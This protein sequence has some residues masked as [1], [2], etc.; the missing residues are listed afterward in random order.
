MLEEERE[1]PRAKKSEKSP[2]KCDSV[3]TLA[4][5]LLFSAQQKPKMHHGRGGEGENGCS[6][7]HNKL[8]YTNEGILVE[9]TV[10]VDFM[11]CSSHI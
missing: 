2:G 6:V 9:A 10:S 3:S 7:P 8:R 1:K 5:F 4:G 11:A